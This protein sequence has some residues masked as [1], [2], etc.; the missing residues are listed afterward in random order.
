MK[1]SF[2]LLL[3]LLAISLVLYVIDHHSA[4]WFLQLAIIYGLLLWLVRIVLL[5]YYRLIKK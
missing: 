4:M 2:I 5:V 1:Y 3:I